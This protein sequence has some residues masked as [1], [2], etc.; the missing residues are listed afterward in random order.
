MPSSPHKPI[1]MTEMFDV[2]QKRKKGAKDCDIIY[3]Y[4]VVMLCSWSILSF[5]FFTKSPAI[6]LA[7]L[8]F[9]PLPFFS[10]FLFFFLFL[11]R[12]V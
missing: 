7:S 11:F 2:N 5:F 1:H 12:I 9:A 3:F 6:K 10:F 4:V 8:V